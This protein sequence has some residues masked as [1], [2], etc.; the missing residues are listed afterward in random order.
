MEQFWDIL[1]WSAIT[2][3]LALLL[4]LLKPLLDKRYSAKW[5]YA[6]WLAMAALL[7]LAPLPWEIVVPQ[8]PVPPPVVIEVPKVEVS[9][10]RQ[11]GLSFQ[12]PAPARTTARPSAPAS[13]RS[14]AQTKSFPLEKALAALWLAGTA[15]FLLYHGLGTLLFLRRGRR[16]SRRPEDEALRVYEAVK[17][18]MGLKKA[19]ALRVSSAAASPMV[20]GLFRP[21]LLLPSGD[22]SELELTFI[23]RHELTHYRRHDLWY[24]LVLMLANGVHWFNPL[25]YLLRREA[26]RDLELTC[27]DAVV[28]GAGADVRR[29]YSETLLASVHRQK[30]W[31]RA[32]LSTH[33]YGGKEV[34]KERFR[35]ILGARGRKWGGLALVLVLLAAVA[36]ACTFGVKASDDG[37]LSEEEL[38]AWQE[39]VESPEMDQYIYRMYSDVSYLPTKEKLD[40]IFPVT[41]PA[42]ELGHE[43]INPKVLSGTRSGD[44]VTL[45]IEG[46][47]ASRLPSGTLT[48][49]N[50]EPVSF[51]TPL[52]TAVEAAAREL[53]DEAVR[54]HMEATEKYL[55]SSDLEESEKALVFTEK[56][57]T[58]LFCTESLTIDG[59]TFYVWELYYRMKPND[60]NNVLLAGGMS[61]ENG[62]V[63]E[64]SSMGSP[65][66]IFSVD[67]DGKIT[68][69]GTTYDSI[70]WEDGFTWE[71]YLYCE[72]NLGMPLGSVL[73]GWPDWDTAFLEDLRNGHYT[74]VMDWQDTALT[75]L[76]QVYGMKPDDSFAELRTFKADEMENDHD[77]AVLVRAVCGERTV[78]LLLAHVIYPVEVWDATLEFWQVC[79]ELW[80]P[81]FEEVVG[82]EGSWEQNELGDQVVLFENKGVTLAFP[83]RDG[84]GNLLADE[85][86][87]NP[88]DDGRRYSDEVLFDIHHRQ[89]YQTN[90]DHTWGGCLMTITK[91]LESDYQFN[92]KNGAYPEDCAFAVDDQGYYYCTFFPF[93]EFSAPPEA[94][95]AMEAFLDSPEYHYMIAD[96]TARNGLT[97]LLD[98]DS[99]YILTSDDIITFTSYF[100]VVSHNGLL[101]TEFDGDFNSVIPC[102]DIILYDLGKPIRDSEEYDALIEAYFED[103]APDT[104]CFK[105]TS[106]EIRNYLSSNYVLPIKTD[107]V[108]DAALDHLK[109]QL[110]YLEEYDAY[111]MVH[112]DTMRVG[113][114]FEGGTRNADGTAVKLNYRTDLWR[115][116]GN[117]E[118]ELL[119]DVPMTAMLLR[120]A[121][122]W[123]LLANTI[124]NE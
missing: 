6:A 36:A 55:Y 100:N 7:L 85:Y 42:S 33:F 43:D 3:A 54:Q 106:E 95:E 74:W 41:D 103:E 64:T 18:D 97:A 37:A 53:M 50:E 90:R 10:S 113:Y 104:D 115:A 89:T 79:G 1:K 34:M 87:V 68:R 12:R 80:E 117:G 63:T 99:E 124:R 61:E 59:K 38:A 102:L 123:P 16:W 27:D 88:E 112:G 49:V 23:L 9:V 32:V 101:R 75:Y 122:G 120:T 118:L 51:T 20:A 62:W 28:A 25:I 60:I 111:Y 47:F 83:A 31:S 4:T 78:T 109:Q 52:Y 84:Q 67:K 69:E 116:D 71:E 13:Q 119:W 65:A 57:I 11:D 5:R 93:R 96:F 114:T 17:A 92:V 26:E 14:A 46:N 35:N 105:L 30:I 110:Y 98:D 70:L 66:L 77:E 107:E 56:Y 8:A 48:L 76:S 24:K 39:K 58:N 19:P 40:E 82:L 108:L 29:A 72:I 81:P 21:K 94:H 44:T 121:D 86:I 15:A 73:N 45:E 2:G 91:I 22:F